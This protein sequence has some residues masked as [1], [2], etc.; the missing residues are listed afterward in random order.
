[1]KN[2]ALI[3]LVFFSISSCKKDTIEDSINALNISGKISNHKSTVLYISN[4]NY[5]K[6]IIINELGEFKDTLEIVEDIYMLQAGEHQALVYLK[7]GYDLSI[8]FDADNFKS[9]ISFSG[10]GAQNNNYISNNA[11]LQES[12]EFSDFNN[13]YTLEE[14]EFESRLNKYIATTDELANNNKGLDSIPLIVVKQSNDQML[15]YL[16]SNYPS[17][18]EILTKL[19][20]GKK[21]PTFS[22]PDI[23]DELISLKSFEGKYVYI[24]VWA[25]WC[26]PCTAQIPYLKQIEKDYENKNIVFIGLSVDT[27]ENKG[28]WEKM[29]AER[30]LKGHQLLADKDWESEFIE[31]YFIKAI[32]RFLLID[33]KGDIVSADAPRPSDPALLRLFNELKI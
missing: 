13:L 11:L 3:V 25:T 31:G 24:D 9:S 18:H 26:G 16:K 14:S 6:E 21:S 5:Q 32:P 1:M 4:R 28:K 22:Y 33:P 20:K 19:A 10:I 8:G 29:V 2:I 17:K 15:R 23:N 27:Q 30:D 12:G 7:N